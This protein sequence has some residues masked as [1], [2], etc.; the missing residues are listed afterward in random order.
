MRAL[1]GGIIG[2]LL[3]YLALP[4]V[5]LTKPQTVLIL[6]VGWMIST[7]LIWWVQEQ[8]ERSQE[9]KRKDDFR[10]LIAKITL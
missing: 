10:R 7:A 2:S 5:G 3:I 9:R 6:I 1:I 8:I 4:D